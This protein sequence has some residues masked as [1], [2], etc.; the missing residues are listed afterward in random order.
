M[1]AWSPYDVPGVDPSFIMNKLNVDPKVV[2]KKQSLRR[3][4]RPHE[5]AMKEEV[6]KLKR[7]GAIQEVF[8]PD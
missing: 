8:F 1:F 4:A 2:P 5:E 6:K 3:S 7:L